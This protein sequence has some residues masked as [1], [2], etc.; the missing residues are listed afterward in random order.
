MFCSDIVSLSGQRCFL[1]CLLGWLKLSLRNPE[2]VE[3][4]YSSKKYYDLGNTVNKMP[5]GG[6]GGHNQPPRRPVDL[7]GTISLAEKNDL[8]T[9]VNAIT[10]KIHKEISNIFDAPPL[11][12][13]ENEQGHNHGLLRSLLHRD[14]KENKPP[15]YQPSSMAKGDGSKTYIKTH[16][17][18]E[19]EEQ[20][21][22]TPQLK[23]LK[24]EAL[25]FF[26]KW[27]NSIL[28]RMRDINVNDP[29]Q[30]QN[31]VRGRGRG[32]R[33][34]PSRGRGGRG[35]AS[36]RARTLA[37]GLNPYLFISFDRS[38]DAITQIPRI[39]G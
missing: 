18:I 4:E 26:R 15:S 16:E 38:R 35:A 17:I 39:Q 34:S 23:E 8:C 2:L 13:V 24:K 25:V 19:K 11:H 30:L 28:Q 12:L 33:G 14:D 37:T 10:E 7:T 20:E 21:A 31:N 29:A 6:R 3:T 5:R 22:L 1:N 32:M 27:Q 9:L 36:P